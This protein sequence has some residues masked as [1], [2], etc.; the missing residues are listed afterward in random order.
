MSPQ[1]I[2]A[3]YALIKLN[4]WMVNEYI[5]HCKVDPTPLTFVRAE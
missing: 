2:L 4:G 3:L 1:I 5:E